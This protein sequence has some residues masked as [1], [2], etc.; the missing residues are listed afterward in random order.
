MRPP[1]FLSPSQSLSGGTIVI[2]GGVVGL[3]IGARLVRGLNKRPVFVVERRALVGQETSSRNS[4]VIHAGIYYPPN[5]L[6]T[7][8]SIQG[9]KDLYSYLSS[10]SIPHRKC[11]K[12]VISTSRS[13]QQYLNCVLTHATNV[14]VPIQALSPQQATEMEPSLSPNVCGAL[15]SPETGIVDS[16]ALM[17][18]LEQE[19]AESE[20]GEVVVGTKVVRIDKAEGESGKGK[21]G[22]G[23]DVG[24]VV[25]LETAG[26]GERDAILC[27]SIINA[28]GLSAHKIANLALK[29]DDTKKLFYAK[30]SY[31]SYRGPGIDGVK[32]LLYPCPR[33][34]L[35]GLGTH[36]TFDMEGKIRFGPDVEWIEPAEGDEEEDFWERHLQPNEERMREA[37]EEVKK[38]LPDVRWEGFQ[39]DYCGIRPKLGRNFHDFSITHDRHGLINLLGIE[40]PGLTSCLSIAKVVEQLLRKE[41][42]R[43]SGKGVTSEV[44]DVADWY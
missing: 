6:K 22:D 35:S 18:S 27:G 4:E 39:P 12:L 34:G 42:W 26:S 17:A 31:F 33:E 24:W 13:Q 10:R 21:R 15:L 41:V 20:Y 37:Y 3:S 38:Y 16:H 30:G 43:G 9:R 40:S 14:G 1:P 2:G 19:I 23:T 11:G 32:K 5:S 8:L 29:D 28:A 44:G 25:Q 7:R 36:L